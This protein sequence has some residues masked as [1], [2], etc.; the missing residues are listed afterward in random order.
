MKCA[1]CL[2]LLCL[3]GVAFTQILPPYQCGLSNN[4]K[5]AVYGTRA[6]TIGCLYF[7]ELDSNG[8]SA[9]SKSEMDDNFVVC[10]GAIDAACA[11]HTFVYNLW[12]LGIPMCMTETSKLWREY[13]AMDG[14]ASA[15][16]FYDVTLIYDMCIRVQNETGGQACYSEGFQPMWAVTWQNVEDEN[17][18]LPHP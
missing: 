7:C 6:A 12:Q 18:T 3:L 14:D 9:V 15:Y 8:N 2:L 4:C 16:I 5:S 13:A 10:A 11:Q 1:I 17:C